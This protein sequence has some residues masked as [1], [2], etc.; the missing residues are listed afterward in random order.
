MGEVSLNGDADDNAIATEVKLRNKTAMSVKQTRTAFS[1]C[2]QLRQLAV[3]SIAAMGLWPLALQVI[4]AP[5]SCTD[6][7]TVLFGSVPPTP[8]TDLVRSLAQSTFEKVRSLVVDQTTGENVG[9]LSVKNDIFGLSIDKS[10]CF[11]GVDAEGAIQIEALISA[12]DSAAFG[13]DSSCLQNSATH[14]RFRVQSTEFYVLDTMGEL[15]PSRTPGAMLIVSLVGDRLNP[16]AS[17]CYDATRRSRH[18]ATEGASEYRRLISLYS[19]Q[20]LVPE[21]CAEFTR[22][23]VKRD[24]F[25]CA[26]SA[27]GTSGAVAD[28]NKDGTQRTYSFPAPWR[29]IQCS[30]SGECSSLLFSQIWLSEWTSEETSDGVVLRHNFVNHKVNEVTVDSTFSIRLVI[31]L[32][33]L[34]LVVTAY[35]TSVRGWYKIR[36]SH[37]SPWATALNATTSC[38]IAKV[39]RS[40]YNFILVAQMVLAIMQWRKQL[41]IDLLVGADTNQALLRAFGCGTLVVVLAINIVF[42]RAGDLKMQEMEP[43]FAH[44]LG[45]LAS[46]MLFLATRTSSVS[47]SA[48]ALLA[49]GMHSVSPSDV[50]K[51]SG[52]RG[53]S[54][55]AVEAS[56]AIYMVVLLVVIAVTTLVG[57]IAHSMLQSSVGT[58]RKVR[59]WTANSN[60]AEVSTHMWSSPTINS[61]TK[62]LDDHSR[63]TDLYD[64]S[65]EVYV[66]AT[67]DTV[68]STRAQ[69]EACGFVQTSSILFRYRDLPLFLVARILPFQVLNFFNI[70]VTTYELIHTTNML[71]GVP[72]DLVADQVI[73]THWSKLKGARLAWLEVYFGGDGDTFYRSTSRK[74][75]DQKGLET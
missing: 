39:V 54:V 40:S 1:V 52:C 3:F 13:V 6:L 38:T 70:T 64:C 66:Q 62:F 56:L 43:S 32:Q 68:L 10:V 63:N 36:C 37:V 14:M 20:L 72:I 4:L 71:D 12:K 15:N 61:F 46:V 45:F 17:S 24:T 22:Y 49:K 59:T 55:C 57:L 69:L 53:S 42:A 60:R 18:A 74:Q 41:T 30:M 23:G 44:V 58:S 9:K 25:G 11:G 65:T 29:M 35:L 27:L 21:T 28:L 2:G 26:Y 73:H 5:E 8:T 50:T 67:G 31:S 19:K 16:V 7:Q 33:I 47:V 34:A 48:R 75:S 51:Y